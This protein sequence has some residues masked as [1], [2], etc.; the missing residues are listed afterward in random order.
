MR[1]DR[2]GKERRPERGTDEPAGDAYARVPKSASQRAPHAAPG[3]PD[4][5]GRR[6]AAPTPPWHPNGRP[7][8]SARGAR[9]ASRL[10][11]PRLPRPAS[12][13]PAAR[14]ARGAP[15]R[16]RRAAQGRRRP[17]T[18]TPPTPRR[19]RRTARPRP[20]RWRARGARR[21]AADRRRARAE[22][23]AAT[24]PARP[25]RAHGA[26]PRGGQLSPP[27]QH[28]RAC[29]QL[30]AQEGNGQRP[31]RHKS[32]EDPRCNLATERRT[33]RA[34]VRSPQSARA[35]AR[36]HEGNT[37]RARRPYPNAKPGF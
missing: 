16:A 19:A 3:A 23:A 11:A 31:P 7:P 5:P 32:D 22:A 34:T 4:P 21:A 8:A 15:W 37:C 25:R 26:A 29:A 33:E 13:S 28:P 30:A 20:W 9:S 14:A 35:A 6:E 24:P 2:R 36:H 12:P 17:A 10:R 27:M 18:R 1:V